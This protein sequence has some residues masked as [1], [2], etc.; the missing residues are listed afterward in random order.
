MAHGLVTKRLD[1][2]TIFLVSPMVCIMIFVWLTITNDTGRFFLQEVKQRLELLVQLVLTL[3]LVFGV[4]LFIAKLQ[5]GLC[6][7]LEGEF[8][9]RQ[10]VRNL[11]NGS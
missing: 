10:L 6:D 3:L 2:T 5:S 7:I 4:E 8:P 1:T 11:C 9:M